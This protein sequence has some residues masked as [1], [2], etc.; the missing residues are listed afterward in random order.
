MTGSVARI[1]QSGRGRLHDLETRGALEIA[2]HGA[3]L[4]GGDRVADEEKCLHE[5]A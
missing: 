1:G 3:R 4:A 2:R 5:Q